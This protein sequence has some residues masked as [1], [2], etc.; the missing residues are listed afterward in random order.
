MFDQKQVDNLLKEYHV[1][2]AEIVACKRFST[3]T[4]MLAANL[5]ENPY[6]AVGHF[7][8]NTSKEELDHLAYLTEIKD[9][10]PHVDELIILTL[11]MLQAEGTACTNEDEFIN[12]ISSFKM[13]IA[14]TVLARKG[15][16]KVNYEN[17]SF[18]DDMSDRIVF[19][20]IEED[21]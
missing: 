4:R 15:L 18:N 6:Y 3:S 1:N 17:L 8:K 13:M 20:P 11:M 7:L 16:I 2:L 21:E 12:Y 19:E 9:D 10:H 14:G 5:M